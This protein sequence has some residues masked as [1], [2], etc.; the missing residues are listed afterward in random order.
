VLAELLVGLVMIA[1]DSSVL[2]RAIHPLDLAVGPR[3]VRFGEAVL[4]AELAT[5]AVDICSL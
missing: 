4:D 2:E 1:P 3:M 5:D